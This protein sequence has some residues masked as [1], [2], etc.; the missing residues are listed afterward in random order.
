[1]SD[2]KQN[3]KKV[4]K[5]MSVEEQEDIG[6]LFMMLEVDRNIKVSRKR[7]ITKLITNK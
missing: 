5:L 1:M 2:Q 4:V 7:V 6:L 3:P